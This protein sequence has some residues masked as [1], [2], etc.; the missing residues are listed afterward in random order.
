MSYTDKNVPINCAECN[1]FVEGIEDMEM[2]VATLHP[3]Y[4]PL[5]IKEHV[6][7]WVEDAYEREAEDLAAYYDDRKLEKQIDESIERDIEFRRAS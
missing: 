4:S 5:E 1:E 6:S 7:L 2:H 3:D